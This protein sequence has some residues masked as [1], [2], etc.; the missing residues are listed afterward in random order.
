MNGTQQP[1]LNSVNLYDQPQS[2]QEQNGNYPFFQQRKNNTNK[3]HTTNKSHHYA[4]NYYPS[5]DDEYYNQNHQGIFSNQRPRSYSIDQPNI[6]EPY[7][8]EQIGKPRYNPKTHNKFFQHQ[9]P[10]NTHSYQPTQTQNEIPLPCYLQKHEITKS[11]LTNF[12]QIPHAAELLII[13]AFFIT[14]KNRKQNRFNSRK[15]INGEF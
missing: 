4:Q 15:S 14:Y 6:F 5:D 3:Y 9:N 2:S 10:F 11:Q 8:N 7:T 1:I 13:L 12:S